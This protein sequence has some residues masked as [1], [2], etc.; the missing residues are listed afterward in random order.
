MHKIVIA[1]MAACLATSASAGQDMT[2]TANR[3]IDSWVQDASRSLDSALDRVDLSRSET[4]I[5]YVRFN[6]DEEGTPQN[7]ATV[8]MGGSKPNLARAGRNAVRK[9]R[10]LHP[11]FEGARPNQLVEA[12]IVVADDQDQLDRLLAEVNERARQQNA[13]WAASGTANPVV[14]LAAAGGF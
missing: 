6:C 1:A 2:V 13:R 5:T 4:G 12:A 10:T 8:R 14:S 9:I 11:L 3:S 7:V